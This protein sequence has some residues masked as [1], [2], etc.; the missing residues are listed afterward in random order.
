[1]RDP[2]RVPHPRPRLLPWGRGT[3]VR[4]V[5]GGPAR[6]RV[7][8]L[9]ASVLAVD[10]ADTATV[11]AT[12]VELERSLHIDNVQIGLLVTAS[13]ALGALATLPMGVLTDRV[14]RTR[15]LCW[16]IV[17]WS[18]AMVVAGAA[19]SYLTLLLTRLALG[20]VIATAGPVVASLTGDL[21]PAADRARVYGFIMSGQ[22]I[23]AGIGFVVSGNVAALLSWRYSFWIL[24]LPGL[25]LAAAIWRLLPEPAR[26]GQSRLAIGATRLRPAQPSDLGPDAPETARHTVPG[27]DRTA[28]EIRAGHIAPHED[29]VL[30]EDPSGR[31]LWWTV[32]YVVSIRTNVVLIIASALGYFFFSGLKTFAVVFMRGRFDVGQS[33]ASILLFVLGT[34]AIAGAITG[35]RVADRL[36]E[37]HR[38][39]ARPVVAGV[40]FALAAAMFLP[41]I[42]TTSLPIAAP[43]FFLAAAGLGGANPP[44]DAARLDLVHSSLWGRAEAIRTVPRSLL[45]AAAPL[46]FGY[47][48]TLF[49]AATLG[50]GAAGQITH[51][52]VALRDT[53]VIMLI[54]VAVA[55]LLLL[56]VARRTYPRDVATVVA[57]QHPTP[58][59]S[60]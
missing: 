1:M 37:G 51:G 29:R 11:G 33:L 57:S 16:A 56:W 6:L 40:A 10:S 2:R 12:A 59:S 18:V 53:F 44:L 38:I 48:S 14:N 34:G 23:G 39:T 35:G 22:L 52:G 7:V 24:V 25:V 28:R 50:L 58:R 3:T 41:G 27:D 32:R 4:D 42:M 8:V 43:L 19:Q 21:I 46:L 9:L 49:G 47:V 60:T 13:T 55:A 45:E 15:L 20:I 17:A 31:S 54:P 36:L 26:G 5:V 30:H